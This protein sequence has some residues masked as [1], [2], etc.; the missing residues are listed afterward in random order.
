MQANPFRSVFVS[1]VHLGAPHSHAKAFGDFLESLNCEKLYLVGDIVD[2]WWIAR[3]RACWRPAETRVI[4]LLRLLPRRGIEVIYTPGN[5]DASMR[6]LIGHNIAGISV[7]SRIDVTLA[8]GRRTLI[9]H[10]DQ[11][12]RLVAFS[13]TQKAIGGYLYD[14]LLG[15]D[16]TMNAVRNSLGLSRISLAHWIKRRNGQTQVYLNRYRAAAHEY[17]RSKGFDGVICGHVHQPEI[18]FS[19]EVIYGN[20]GDW[21][22]NLTAIGEDARGDLVR[23]R[24]DKV[25]MSQQ[26]Q[27]ALTGDILGS[28][29]SLD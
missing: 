18:H 12:D 13:G 26:P 28:V 25:A 1:D 7:R 20:C 10:G 29:T 27:I 9:T 3:R 15:V 2:L 5:H 17:A 11:F 6:S 23:L 8:N 21:V 19:K 24:W 14:C 16:A 22:E 4:N